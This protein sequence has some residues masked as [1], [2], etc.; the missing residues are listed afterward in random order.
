[1]RVMTRVLGAGAMLLLLSPAPARADV[2]L[3]PF[4]GVTFGGDAKAHKPTFGGAVTFFGNGLGFEFEL[5]H[6]PNFFGDELADTNVTTISANIVGGG[7]V[8][9]AKNVKVYFVAGVGLMRTG[10]SASELTEEAHYNNFGINLGGGVNY[11]ITQHV[12]LTGGVR[13]FRRL[14]KAS[15]N[16]VIPIASNFDFFRATL[17]VIAH[18]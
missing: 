15:D 10:L 3:S 7:D 14:E 9:N 13:Y 8:K 17:G 16:G 11:L 1:M 12:G 5:A 2:M 6:T 18:F 4:A